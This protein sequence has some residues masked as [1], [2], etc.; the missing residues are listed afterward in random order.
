M[1]PHLPLIV[2]A[3]YLTG[4][5]GLLVVGVA[6]AT[7]ANGLSFVPLVGWT[8]PWS[9]WLPPSVLATSV[10]ALTNATLLS[11]LVRLLLSRWTRRRSGS[12]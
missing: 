7:H 6:G 9:V 1:R 5:L 3:A 2:G 11:A 4:A 12:A 10:A 8:L